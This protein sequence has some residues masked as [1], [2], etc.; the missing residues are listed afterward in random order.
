MCHRRSNIFIA[1]NL[2]LPVAGVELPGSF[3]VGA[4]SGAGLPGGSP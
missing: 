4:V 2:D 1:A 3:I